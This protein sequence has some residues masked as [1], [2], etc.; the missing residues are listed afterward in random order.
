[1]PAPTKPSTESWGVTASRSAGAAGSAG[2]WPAKAAPRRRA[3]RSGTA[4]HRLPAHGGIV[5]RALAIEC[6]YDRQASSCPSGRPFEDGRLE[7][8]GD[9]R[10]GD[11]VGLPGGEAEV[12]GG[13]GQ[14]QE[15]HD[16]CRR[17]LESRR[18]APLAP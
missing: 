11:R 8:P 18:R 2:K 14:C 4:R 10:R 16:P 6:R 13:A 12:F 15:V 7:R 17:A 9:S 5:R 3:A 1:M